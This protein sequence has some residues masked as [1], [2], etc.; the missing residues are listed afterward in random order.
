MIS[1][2]VKRFRS[3]LLLSLTVVLLASCTVYAQE[4]KAISPKVV[5]IGVPIYPP[6]ARAAHVEGIVHIKRSL[7]DVVNA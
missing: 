1:T 6:L 2:L 3:I 5:T 7:R 4:T